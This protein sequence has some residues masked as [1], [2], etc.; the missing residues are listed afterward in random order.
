MNQSELT[1]RV[2]KLWIDQA[3]M[4]GEQRMRDPFADIGLE[5]SLGFGE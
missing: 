2:R 4:D 5:Q 3:S 1:E